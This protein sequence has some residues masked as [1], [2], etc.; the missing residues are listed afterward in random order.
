MAGMQQGRR[1]TRLDEAAQRGRITIRGRARRLRDLAPALAETAVAAGVAWAIAN[2][3]LGHSRPFMA[4]VAAIIALGITY[5]QRTRRAAEIVVGVAVGVLAADLLARWLG[6]GPV[7]IALVTLLAM[8]AAVFLGGQTLVVTQAAVSAIFIMTV[9]AANSAPLDRF[10]DALVGGTVALVANLVVFPLEPVR[11]AQRAARPLLEEL[12]AVLDDVAGALQARDHDAAV[13][14]LV[15]ARELDGPMRRFSDAADVGEEVAL[16]S[17]LRRGRRPALARYRAAANHVD[18][19]VRNARVLARGAVRAVDLDAHV[20]ED[21]IDALREL[22]GAVRTLAPALDDPELTAVA[23]EQAL[24]AAGRATLSLERTGNLSASVLVGQ[25]R[26]MAVDLL[27]GLGVA[28]HDAQL[29]VR[30]A[31]A[32][33]ERDGLAEQP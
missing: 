7:Q 31:A 11:L 8:S 4:P 26:S 28:D 25:V 22:A 19:A 30:Q 27:Q 23:R 16:F 29:A 9:T 10:V 32:R 18:L 3:V 21:T 14:A 5:G 6:A 20:P 12:A 24:T 1:T 2:G 33:V 17:P 15:R 13:D